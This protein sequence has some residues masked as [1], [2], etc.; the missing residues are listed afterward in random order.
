M[1]FHWPLVSISS[2]YY[3]SI[4]GRSYSWRSLVWGIDEG[5]P[6]ELGVY[7]NHYILMSHWEPVFMA[8]PA[9]H[10]LSQNPFIVQ[11]TQLVPTHIFS[12]FSLPPKRKPRGKV[13]PLPL[14]DVVVP[15]TAAAT[16]CRRIITWAPMPPSPSFHIPILTHSCPFLGL[17]WSKF[18]SS[19]Y[20]LQRSQYVSL[21][22]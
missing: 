4:P 19:Y 12:F 15:G 18:Q 10:I 13:I 7:V 1:S 20:F 21:K 3:E 16:S 11:G 6:S 17:F 2:P 22:D 5:S 8:F 9:L 14:L